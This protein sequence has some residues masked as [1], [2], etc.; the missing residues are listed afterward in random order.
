[1]NQNQFNI[2]FGG[3]I[4][5]KKLKSK[6]NLMIT[7]LKSAVMNCHGEGFI[8][9]GLKILISIII[10]SLLLAGLYALFGDVILF[11]SRYSHDR[12]CYA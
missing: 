5:M 3:K 8:D 1:V 6:M 10:G 9:S 7:H 2:I 11:S 12:D 4:T